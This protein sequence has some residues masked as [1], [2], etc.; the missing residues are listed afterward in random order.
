VCLSSDPSTYQR[1][2]YALAFGGVG[3]ACDGLSRLCDLGLYCTSS[4]TCQPLASVGEA[5]G[6]GSYKGGCAAPLECGEASV[7][8]SGAE[9]GASCSYDA[10][11]AS[12][13]GCG[14]WPTCINGPCAST[15]EPLTWAGS[16]EPCGG[17]TRCLVG[18][19]DGTTCQTVIPEGQP[20][21]GVGFD[22]TCDTFAECFNGTCVLIDGVTCP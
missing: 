11:C 22:A 17:Y 6:E 15:C 10:D 14:D 16:G 9:E 8:V 12:G 3:A 20:C 19:C 13:L 2:C 21:Q 4:W 1:N 7:C 5:C 18:Y